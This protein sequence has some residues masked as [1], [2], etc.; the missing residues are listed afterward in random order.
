LPPCTKQASVAKSFSKHPGNIA[1]LFMP[2]ILATIPEAAQWV[3]R[4]PPSTIHRWVKAGM[5]PTYNVEGGGDKKYVNLADVE[6]L[7]DLGRRD[8][9]RIKARIN[10]IATDGGGSNGQQDKQDR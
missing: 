2:V 10:R 5:L 7:V 6:A 3:Q 8:R 9:N 1:K 4:I